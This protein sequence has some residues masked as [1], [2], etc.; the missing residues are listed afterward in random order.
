M[1]GRLKRSVQLTALFLI[2]LFIALEFFSFIFFYFNLGSTA[3]VPDFWIKNRQQVDTTKAWYTEYHDWGTW[4]VESSKARHI[5]V[6]YSY[7][8]FSNSYGARDIQRSMKGNNRVVFLGDS[9]VEGRAVDD[10]GRMTNILEEHFRTEFLNFGAVG[11]GPL[12]Y[13]IIYNKLAR[14]FE[15]DHVIVGFLPLNDFTDNDLNFWRPISNVNER[16]RPFYSEDG[17][18]AIYTR[19]KPEKRTIVPDENSWITQIGKRYFWSYGLYREVKWI[20]LKYKFIQNMWRSNYSGYRDALDYQINNTLGSLRRLA[21]GAKRNN[22]SFTV[23]LFPVI[24]DYEAKNKG[25]DLKIKKIFKDFAEKEEINYVDLI[26]LID[27]DPKLYHTCDGHW[28]PHGNLMVANA[29]IEVLPD[30]IAIRKS[31][32]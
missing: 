6:C 15:H 28:S 5:T 19:K 26:D 22:K 3:Y 27:F 16:Y 9:F 20:L 8:Y 11:L 30:I 24:R 14:K 32:K 4:H 18:G 29:L 31:D 1:M 23:V 10:K 25:D 13:E 17:E 7:G 2:P 21:E 12:Q